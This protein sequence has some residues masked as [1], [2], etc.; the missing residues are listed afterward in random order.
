M[1]SQWETGLGLFQRRRSK[2]IPWD[3][4]QVVAQAAL[5]RLRQECQSIEELRSHYGKGTYWCLQLARRLFPQESATIWDP[6]LTADVA[7]AQRYGELASEAGEG[8][9]TN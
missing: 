1:L 7:Y 5:E 2:K 9:A 8:G 6:H 4:Y 3:K